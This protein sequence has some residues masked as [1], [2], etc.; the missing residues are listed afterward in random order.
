MRK[1]HEI[2]FNGLFRVC[3]CACVCLADLC[4]DQFSR[5]GV[6]ALSGQCASLGG[7]CGKSCGSC[8]WSG[9]P[10][11]QILPLFHLPH[12]V[13]LLC[14]PPSLLSLCTPPLPLC[15]K[16]FCISACFS[17]SKMFHMCVCSLDPVCKDTYNPKDVDDCIN[18]WCY[19]TSRGAHKATE[20]PR[21]LFF[22]FLHIVSH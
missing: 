13:V 19:K 7:S 8:W 11:T 3:V 5:C 6:A 2:D 18:H 4:R 10:P 14:P 20:H 16:H 12:H 17:S 1:N 21:F 9:T 15:E 22:N